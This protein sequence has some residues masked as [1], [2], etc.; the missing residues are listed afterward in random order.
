MSEISI[1]VLL[2]Y[3]W[4]PIMTALTVLWSRVVGNERDLAVRTTLLEQSALHNKQQRVEERLLRDEQR[5]EILDR[6]D[7]HHNL[8][9]DKLDLVSKRLN[10]EI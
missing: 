7:V 4:I 5:R 1:K 2:D 6:I 10:K 3:V 8:V 9:M